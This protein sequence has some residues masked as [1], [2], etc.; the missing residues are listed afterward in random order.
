MCI[1]S[2]KPRKSPCFIFL[3]KWGLEVITEKGY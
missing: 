2:N 3:C 1:I